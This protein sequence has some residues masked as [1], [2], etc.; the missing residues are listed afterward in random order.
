MLAAPKCRQHN[1]YAFSPWICCEI[2]YHI[3]SGSDFLELEN[4][5]IIINS[6]ILLC[7]FF[8]YIFND[9]P[10]NMLDDMKRNN[11]WRA[12][13]TFIFCQCLAI[14]LCIC[15]ILIMVCNIFLFLKLILLWEWP[16]GLK[17][18]KLFKRNK[19]E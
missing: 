18:F 17:N 1:F 9:K 4:K 5:K 12:R 14:S 2:F 16:L 7:S 10:L 3:F 19:N 15:W 13:R 8:A 6:F 11:L